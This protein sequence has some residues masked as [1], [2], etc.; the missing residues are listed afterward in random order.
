MTPRERAVAALS[1]KTPDRVPCV[2]LVDTSY[3]AACAKMPV[4]ECFLNPEAYAAALVATLDRHPDIDGVSINI[5]LSADVILEHTRSKGAHHV[6]TVGG[7]TWM[8][9][10]ND[11]GTS[12]PSNRAR[13]PIFP[14]P[15]LG[16]MSI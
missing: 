1:G 12:G 11:I 8:V 3:A 10:E 15:A 9:P 16:P 5:G 4:S 6:R 2:P 13:S 14:T 7:L